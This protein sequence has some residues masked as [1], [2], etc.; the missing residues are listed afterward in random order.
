MLDK[1]VY[2]ALGRFEVAF[3][4]TTHDGIIQWTILEALDRVFAALAAV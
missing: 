1:G 4:S 2:F 3:L